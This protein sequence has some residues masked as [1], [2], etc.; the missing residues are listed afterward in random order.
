MPGPVLRTCVKASLRPL[1]SRII[2]PGVQPVQMK[3]S[4]CINV[5]CFVLV[6]LTQAQ[7]LQW[8][9][10]NKLLGD[11]IFDGRLD[12]GE[13]VFEGHLDLDDGRNILW[14]RYLMG[15]ISSNTA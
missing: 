13:W 10:E 7:S 5:L 15:A 3:S 2:L 8:R 14:T 1:A 4:F 11:M 12:L 9:K 6:I